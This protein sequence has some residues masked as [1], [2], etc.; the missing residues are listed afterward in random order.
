MDPPEVDGKVS[1]SDDFDTKAGDL[2]W[3]QIIYA[4]DHYDWGVKVED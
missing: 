4:D 1:L 3:V 2:I